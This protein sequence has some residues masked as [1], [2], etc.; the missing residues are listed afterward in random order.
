MTLKEDLC[1]NTSPNIR[2][3]SMTVSSFLVIYFLTPLFPN[4][5]ISFF[6][7]I[8]SSPIALIIFYIAC[9]VGLMNGMNFIDGANGILSFYIIS[10]GL[11]LIFLSLE[12]NDLNS[13]NIFI[14]FL[15][16]YFIFLFFNFPFGKIFLGDF[17][18]YFSGFIL[19]IFLINF[20]AQNPEIYYLNAGLIFFYPIF[21]LVFSFS[22]KIFFEKIS[23]FQPDNQHLHSI[24]YSYL[25]DDK[26]TKSN[27]LVTI[28]LL[29]IIFLPTLFLYIF[30]N[31]PKFILLSIIFMVMIYLFYYFFF[32][33]ILKKK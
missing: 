3:L 1:Q 25:Y 22:R 33:S 24:I 4:V 2:L 29:P 28:I 13:T 9:M 19:G 11:S 15:I 27:Y 14:Y 5:D 20:F 21:E 6:N 18:A 23:P 31:S 12:V 7:S 26:Y 32:K 17:G 10:A 16:P 30:Y 8:F